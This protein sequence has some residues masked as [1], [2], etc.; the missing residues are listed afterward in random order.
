MNQNSVSVG[1]DDKYTIDKEK[2]QNKL[3]FRG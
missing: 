3:R 1:E 2:L